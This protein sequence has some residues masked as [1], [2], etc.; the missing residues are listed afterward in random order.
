MKQTVRRRTM[1]KML[2][3]LGVIM[4]LVSCSPAPTSE[5]PKEVA[6]P[7]PT[8]APATEAVKE[9]WQVAQKLT[10]THAVY[11]AGFMNESFGMTVGYGGEVHYT[12]DGGASWPQAANSSKCRFGLEIVDDQVAWHCGNGGHVRKSTDG[13]KT[14]QAVADFGPSEPNQCRF[15]SFLDD[16]TGW[17]ATPSQLAATND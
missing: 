14:W 15:L 5:A 6:S 11:Y 12:N 16:T 17:A 9:P 7:Q 1:N 4:I 10:Y 13:G 3:F 8:V 2:L